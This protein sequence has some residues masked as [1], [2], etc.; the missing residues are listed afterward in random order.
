VLALPAYKLKDGQYIT[1]RLA[2]DGRNVGR[3]KKHVLI[4]FCVMEGMQVSD[5][6]KIF[7]IFFPL[8]VYF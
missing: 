8:R 3:K 7:N 6:S 2:G 5:S 1:I 4:T